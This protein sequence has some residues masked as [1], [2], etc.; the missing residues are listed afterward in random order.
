MKS[1]MANVCSNTSFCIPSLFHST[2]T[3][4][5]NQHIY[6]IH[7]RCEYMAAENGKLPKCFLAA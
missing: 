3:V 5:L 7:F 2:K 6:G 1:K 4:S